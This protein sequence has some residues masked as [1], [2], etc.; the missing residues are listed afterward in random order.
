MDMS[1]SKLRE[2]VKDR[3][4]WRAAVH[5]VTKS[6]TRSSDWTATNNK[7]CFT[8]LFWFLP[9]INMHQPQVHIC[10]RPLEPPSYLPL[11]PAPLGLCWPPGWTPCVT[12]RLPISRHFTCGNAYISVLLSRFFLPSPPAPCDL[13][14]TVLVMD[15]GARRAT[16]HRVT[17][18][19]TRLRDWTNWTEN[20]L[21][22]KDQWIKIYSNIYHL[23]FAQLISIILSFICL[24]SWEWLNQVLSWHWFSSE[25]LR[26]RQ[27]RRLP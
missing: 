11:H 27:V 5:G 23:L 8:M 15:R 2:I 25:K 13:I 12:Q 26:H 22:L 24:T 18:S 6:W 17:E 4:A 19:Q 1:L 9:Y 20:L 16:V 14:T 3:E 21:L 7:I 10:S